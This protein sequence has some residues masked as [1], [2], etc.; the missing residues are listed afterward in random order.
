MPMVYK[1][2]SAVHVYVQIR[3]ERERL[4]LAFRGG[5]RGSRGKG[6]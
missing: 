3:E 2:L 5:E 6:G 4:V 1:R